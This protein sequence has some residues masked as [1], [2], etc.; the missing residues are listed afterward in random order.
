MKPSAIVWL[1]L[2]Q[3][4]NSQPERVEE[5]FVVLQANGVD[6]PCLEVAFTRGGLSR[7][8]VSWVVSAPRSPV[9]ASLHL[10]TLKPKPSLFGLRAPENPLL[11]PSLLVLIQVTRRERKGWEFDRQRF[12]DYTA[13]CWTI[14]YVRRCSVYYLA[15][16]CRPFDI[17]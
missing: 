4:H 1:I 13:I 2:S 8:D 10:F 6:L 12:A 14:L 5:D 17:I 16:A 11:T 3:G 15:L 9:Q 7:G